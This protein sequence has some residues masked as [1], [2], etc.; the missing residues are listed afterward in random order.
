MAKKTVHVL[1]VDNYFPEMCSVTLPLIQRYAKK[2]GAEFNLI[3]ERRYPDFPP[4]YE[5]VQVY[6]YGKDSEWNILLDADLV[7]SEG[8][9]DVTLGDP[10][11][12]LA[13]SMFDASSMFSADQYFLRDGRNIGIAGGM[14]VSSI[15]THDLWT[16]LEFGY[17]EASRRSKRMHILDEYCISRNLA[18][19]GLKFGG[20]GHFENFQ[21][22]GVADDEPKDA[23]VAKA[24]E[25][26]GLL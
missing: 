13:Q 12:V 14:V 2:I 7:V 23:K 17:I 5:K 16:P 8:A 21:H 24:K 1:C 11:F 19:F 26:A 9:P 25:M 18:R 20:V 6:D 4:T 10:S 3:T 15:Y 22:I